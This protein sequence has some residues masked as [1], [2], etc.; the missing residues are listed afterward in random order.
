MFCSRKEFGISDNEG[1]RNS[2]LEISSWRLKVSVA[3]GW[4]RYVTKRQ[5]K[6]L[7]PALLLC[8]LDL[9]STFPLEIL[10][11][12]CQKA[13]YT[14][15][16]AS[17]RHYIIRLHLASFPT[18]FVCLFVCLHFTGKAVLNPALQKTGIFPPLLV[19]YHLR[20]CLLC[21]CYRKCS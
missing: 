17:R 9:L 14:S 4:C 20:Q 10:R 12:F 8:A 18:V 5:S 6:E 13:K 3:L 21:S 16:Q 19:S 2:L 11:G 15:D 7:G 1:S